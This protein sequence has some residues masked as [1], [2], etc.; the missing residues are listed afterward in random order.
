MESRTFQNFVQAAVLS[1][2]NCETL[3]FILISVLDKT[4]K[5]ILSQKFTFES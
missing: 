3:M 2:I 4:L 5:L 1:K